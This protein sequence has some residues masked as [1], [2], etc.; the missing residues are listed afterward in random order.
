MLKVIYNNLIIDLCSQ[1]RYL[2]YL[3]QQKRFI[4][5]KKYM[6]NAI[7]GSDNNT[8]YHLIGTPYNFPSEIKTVQIYKIEQEEFDRLQA[9]T[10]LQN[11]KKT[12]DLKREVDDLK[13]LV[14]QQNNLIQQLL[15]KLS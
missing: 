13:E 2:K 3:P 1:E 10:M 8:V 4:E 11:S 14:V 9:T 15:E 7:L 6:A 5:V 12:I